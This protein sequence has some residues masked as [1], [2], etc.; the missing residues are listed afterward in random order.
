M[1]S[2]RT[3]TKRT[4]SDLLSILILLGSAA[5][6]IAAVAAPIYRLTQP[7]G[8]VPVALTEPAQNQAV[9]AVTGLPQGTWLE[10]GSWGFPF[11]WHVLDLSWPLRLLTE[12]GTSLLFGCLAVAGLLLARVVRTISAGQP[13]DARNPRRL[14][15][16]A[17]LILT[18]GIGSQYLEA[19]T[20]FTLLNRTGAAPDSALA[21][22]ANLNLTWLF[23]FAI[24]VVLAQAFDRG[25]SMAD[26]V[27]G[28]I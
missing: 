22:S 21:A 8:Q 13:F 1:S 14:R 6:A 7:G 27:E 5:A 16:I 9:A 23:I 20:R 17:V 15:I 28:L 10:F 3:S 11:Q 19:I 26:D 4:G 18:G 25:R 12:A 2:A 24:I